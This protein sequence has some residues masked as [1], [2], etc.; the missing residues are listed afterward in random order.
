MKKYIISSLFIVF[1][2]I[3]IFFKIKNKIIQN[4]INKDLDEFIQILQKNSSSIVNIQENMDIKDSLIQMQQDVLVEQQIEI[5]RLEQDLIEQEYLLMNYKNANSPYADIINNL[6][7]GEMDLLCTILAAEARGESIKGQRAAVEVIL[8]R[9]MSKRFPNTIQGVLSSPMQFTTW[10]NRVVGKYSNI[11]KEVVE[12]VATE[13]PV[14]P[15]LHYVY[16]SKGISKYMNDPI[17]IGNHW[18]GAE[19]S[20]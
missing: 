16:F 13:T 2:F 19:K 4:N 20:D 14:L 9:M 7:E 12:L 11:Q 1:S 8:N 3:I 5:L 15:S 6:T 17:Q 10:K 18:F